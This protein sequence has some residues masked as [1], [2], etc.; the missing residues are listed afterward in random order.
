MSSL[1]SIHHLRKRFGT[2]LLL[3]IERL[4]LEKASATVLTGINGSGKST[5]LRILCG[6]ENA[7][8]TSAT[9]LGSPVTLSLRSPQLRDSVVYVHQHPVMFS[10][11]V[12]ANVG[13]GL[14]ARGRSSPLVGWRKAARRAGARA[15]AATEVAAA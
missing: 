9:F 10:S 11:S 8:Y 15:R 6:L 13:Y 12:D 3:D 4:D 7:E 1:L 5:L 2:R 14:A